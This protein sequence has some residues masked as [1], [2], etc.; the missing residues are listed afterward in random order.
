MT[1]EKQQILR[2]LLADLQMGSED[3]YLIL[4]NNAAAKY[5]KILSQVL[6]NDKSLRPSSQEQQ[7]AG[8]E[9]EDAL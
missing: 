9:S 4:G 1:Q 5:A 3:L 8:A 2:E 6:D 7:E